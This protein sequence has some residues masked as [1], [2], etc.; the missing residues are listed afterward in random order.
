MIQMISG[1]NEQIFR[2]SRPDNYDYLKK[3]GILSVLCLENDR[4][5]LIHENMECYNRGMRFVGL[6]LDGFFSPTTAQ[7]LLGVE[8]MKNLPKPLLVHCRRGIDRTGYLIAKYRMVVQGWPY[9][10]AWEE[11]K[12]EGHK[13][14]PWYLHWKKSLR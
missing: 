3:I 2:G 12:A 1:T 7:L 8:W 4:Y 14:F 10:K 9:E 5:V 13:P 11:C 6:P